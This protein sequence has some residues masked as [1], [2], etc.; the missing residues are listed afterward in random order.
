MAKEPS[1][2]ES[3]EM[4]GTLDLSMKKSRSPEFVSNNHLVHSS[5]TTHHHQ[6][7]QQQQ[8]STNNKNNGS[9]S[10]HVPMIPISQLQ[11]SSH[12]Y[13]QS[14][15]SSP[16]EPANNYYHHPSHQV[17]LSN[18]NVLTYSFVY[19]RKLYFST[20]LLLPKS[21]LFC[22]SLYFIYFYRVVSYV[23]IP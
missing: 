13:K 9:H 15:V 2:R 12:L 18:I 19:L 16:H 14:T 23:E 21:L 20:M 1:P 17:P 3:A 10:S 5:Q 4:S 22:S 11:T 8:T 7:Q 6:Q